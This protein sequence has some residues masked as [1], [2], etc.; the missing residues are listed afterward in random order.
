MCHGHCQERGGPGIRHPAPEEFESVLPLNGRFNQGEEH[1]E[2]K[3]VI[4]IF[5]D[6]KEN[7]LTFEI[8]F[9]N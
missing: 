3:E 9:Y 8:I 7:L 2:G 1:Y 4:M 5:T 6:V